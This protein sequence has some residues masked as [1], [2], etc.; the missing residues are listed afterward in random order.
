MNFGARARQEAT[1]QNG[2]CGRRSNCRANEPRRVAASFIYNR[3]GSTK[4]DTIVSADRG[5]TNVAP[6]VGLVY[7]PSR[8]WQFHA[9]VGTGYGTPQFTNLFVTPQGQPGNNTRL[10]SQTNVGYDVGADWT[11]VRG[12]LLSVTGFYEFFENEL[13]SQSPGPGLP[14]FTFNAP[15][16]E[17]RGME[18]AADIALG[19]GF[20]LTAAYIYNNQIYTDCTE[21]LP[22][23]APPPIPPDDHKF[24]SFNRAGN[25][26]PGVSPNALTARLSYDVRDGIYKGWGL[27]PNISGTMASIW[28]TPI[29][30]KR[31][32]TTP[33]TSMCI[34]PPSLAAGR[35]GRSWPI[36]RS[37]TFSTRRTSPRQ[38][39]SRTQ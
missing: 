6:E 1:D 37:G 13:V 25:K 14:N 11:P 9:R 34:T 20:R 28:K 22:N 35:C 26:I 15:A 18:A 2:C 30:L 21:Q 3:D 16:S 19:A 39:T 32:V 38:T 23:N 4:S 33:S 8:D 24:F 7:T 27:M 17:H 12:V 5:I 31:R 29:C 36:S 10:K